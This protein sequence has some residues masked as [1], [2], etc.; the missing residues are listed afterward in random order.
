M[1]FYQC[2][3]KDIIEKESKKGNSYWVV[4]TKDKNSSDTFR[5]WLKGG[6]DELHD[7]VVSFKG[8][9]ATIQLKYNKK[10]K[11]IFLVDIDN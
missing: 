6:Q 10:Y 4:E 2:K 7:K 8:K 11:E 5:I 3:I 1:F 9:N